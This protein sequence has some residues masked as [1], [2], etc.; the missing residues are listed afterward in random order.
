[1]I[2]Y[3]VS[4]L[5]G[6]GKSVALQVMEDMG[7]YCIDNLPAALLPSFASQTAEADSA[8]LRNAAV[9]IDARNRRFLMPCRKPGGTQVP[10][11][12]Y[13]IIFPRPTTRC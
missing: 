7:F 2:V 1:M 5:S 4:G 10:G 6:S 13:R 9:G 3:I 8:G 11:L 12:Q